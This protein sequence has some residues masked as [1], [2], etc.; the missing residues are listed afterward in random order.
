MGLRPL[1]ANKRGFNIIIF[2][3]NIRGKLSVIQCEEKIFFFILNFS[4]VVILLFCPTRYQKSIS[5]PPPSI[6]KFLPCSGVEKRGIP[7]GNDLLCSLVRKVGGVPSLIMLPGM[8]LRLESSILKNIK[9]N[10]SVNKDDNIC[11]STT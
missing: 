7:L 8:E 9:I 3:N 1:G 5:P 11:K 10:I 4:L 2:H 6:Y